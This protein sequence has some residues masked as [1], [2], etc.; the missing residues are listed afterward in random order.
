MDFLNQSLKSNPENMLIEQWNFGYNAGIA[1]CIA[2]LDM[3]IKQEKVR[4]E[5]AI[6]LRNIIEGFKQGIV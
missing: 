1:T 6:L 5:E 3:L 4:P 2:R